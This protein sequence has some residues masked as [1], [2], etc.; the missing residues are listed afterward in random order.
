MRCIRKTYPTF[1]PRNDFDVLAIGSR[2]YKGPASGIYT[3]LDEHFAIAMR[4]TG[5]AESVLEG[6]RRILDREGTVTGVR[7]VVILS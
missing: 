5:S 2:D 1:K 6:C 7:E 3:W 4:P